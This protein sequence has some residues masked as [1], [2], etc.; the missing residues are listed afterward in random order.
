MHLDEACARAYSIGYIDGDGC[1]RRD[2]RGYLSIGAVGTEALLLWIK[3]H[4]EN[5][6]AP[7]SG[8]TAVRKFNHANCYQYTT[9][10][11][12][13]EEVYKVLKAHP[14]P[15]RLARKWQYEF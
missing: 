11:K 14:V 9:T 1:V 2:N 12:H 8:G 7:V 3:A 13:A 5:I 15:Y 10:G 6:C 4:F